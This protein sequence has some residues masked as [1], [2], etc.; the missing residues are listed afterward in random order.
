[1]KCS[2]IAGVKDSPTMPR[3]PETLIIGSL[4]GFS[5]GGIL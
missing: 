2:A 1:M 5:A 3:K 4:A